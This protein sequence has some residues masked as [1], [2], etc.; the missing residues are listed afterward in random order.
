M[1]LVRLSRIL[2]S[3]TSDRQMIWL[4]E[5]DGD[6][7]F[8]IVIGLAEAAAIDRNVK[9]IEPPRPL[10]HD[11]LARVITDLGGLVD[12]VEITALR[13]DTFYA[14]IVV[15]RADEEIEFDSRPSDAIALA[16]GCD[17]PIFV[18]EDVLERAAG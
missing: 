13:H 14:R 10:T 18:A 17:R 12:R 7:S 15:A 4:T 3:E 5:V 2:I 11:L 9:S 6:R 8:P 16:V 1:I